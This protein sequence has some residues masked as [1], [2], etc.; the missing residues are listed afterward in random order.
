MPT[1]VEILQQL[2]DKATRGVPLTP[3]EQP[4]L[5][6]WYARLDQAERA[7]LAG[8]RRHLVLCDNQFSE[9]DTPMVYRGHVKNGVVVLDEQAAL[10]EGAEVRVELAGAGADRPV[11]DESGQTLGQKL[12]KY[13]GR[14][15]DLPADAARNHDH[16]LYGTPKK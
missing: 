15:V 3:D 7:L 6:A 5:E 14:A 12:L 4:R 8:R 16:Y 11:L 2:H 10:P 1:D 9:K 13:A